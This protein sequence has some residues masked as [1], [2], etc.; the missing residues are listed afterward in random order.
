MGAADQQY[1]QYQYPQAPVPA[2]V[3]KHRLLKALAGIAAG[4]VVLVIG[5][6]IGSAGRQVK[7]VA[8]PAVTVTATATQQVPGPVV[9]ETAVAPAPAAG[10]V[11]GKYKGT[12]NQ[13]TPSFNVPDSG[14]YIVRWSYTGNSDSYG[15]T[16]FAISNTG[17]GMGLGLPND[18]ADHGSGSTQV[19]GA[20]GTDSLNVQATGSWTVTVTAA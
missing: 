20:T 12:G 2:P 14:S 8:S 6:A 7:T 18:I 17:D 11:I 5:I 9:T 19:T 1:Q 15:P 4:I 16:N 13:V 3:K 10:G